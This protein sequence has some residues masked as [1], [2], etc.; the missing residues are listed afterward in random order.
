MAG[1][2][3]G[4]HRGVDREILVIDLVEEHAGMF[5][6]D[7]PEQNRRGRVI[8]LV[9]LERQFI[10]DAEDRDRPSSVWGSAAEKQAYGV[11]QWLTRARN[12]RSL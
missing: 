10:G 8:D 4:P 3:D 11:E 12:L 1:I 2:D 5:A 6:V 7:Q 9:R